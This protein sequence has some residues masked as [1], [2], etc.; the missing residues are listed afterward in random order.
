MTCANRDYTLPC[1]VISG[2]EIET[3]RRRVPTKPAKNRVTRAGDLS[4]RRKA[5]DSGIK[6]VVSYSSPSESG[7]R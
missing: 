4:H 2:D 5:R 1:T 6:G 7:K 3:N